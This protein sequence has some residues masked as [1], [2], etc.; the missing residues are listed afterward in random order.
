MAE[1]FRPQER[2]A[3]LAPHTHRY[4]FRGEPTSL[5]FP[6]LC[7]HCGATASTEVACTKVFARTHS[8]SSPTYVTTTLLVPFCGDCARRHTAQSPT[9]SR[10]ADLLSTFSNE[11]FGAVTGALGAAFFVY[12]GLTRVLRDPFGATIT[13]GVA[14]LIGW[15]ARTMWRM[16]WR[17]SEYRRVSP[18]TDMTSAFDFS[19]D[20][21]SAFESARFVCTVRDAR[22]A[23]SLARLNADRL[24]VATSPEAQ[25]EQRRASRKLWLVA[26]AVGLLALLVLLFTD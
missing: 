24:W 1:R 12:L 19:D 25:A 14:A 26:V 10:W 11:M 5:V 8:D 2:D 17:D 22:F 21:S 7:P 15:Y 9:H 16:A 20:L 4:T 18:Q 23:E 13:F 3:R 6:P